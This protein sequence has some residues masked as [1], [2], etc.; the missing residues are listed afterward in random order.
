MSNTR[1]RRRRRPARLS[2]AAIIGILLLL[3]LIPVLCIVIGSKQVD[4]KIP[5]YATG[6]VSESAVV[7]DSE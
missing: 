7:V 2:F 5:D 1:R 6:H 3:L 4:D